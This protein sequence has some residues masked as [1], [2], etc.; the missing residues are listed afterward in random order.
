MSTNQNALQA[1]SRGLGCSWVNFDWDKYPRGVKVTFA[2]VDNKKLMLIKKTHWNT[3]LPEQ[4]LEKNETL[5]N[6]LS[7]MHAELKK[8]SIFVSAKK[9]L[10]TVLGTAELDETF[11]VILLVP[12]GLID[13][14][15]SVQIVASS[16]MLSGLASNPMKK[17]LPKV[18][19]WSNP[20]YMFDLEKQFQAA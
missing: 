14:D 8:M 16:D 7:K 15:R 13:G 12:V 1:C 17:Y 19:D 20:D 5:E 4:V 3:V 2:L 6:V 9:G 18:L 10:A 11:H